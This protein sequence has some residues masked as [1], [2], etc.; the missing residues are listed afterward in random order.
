M[1]EGLWGNLTVQSGVSLRHGSVKGSLGADVLVSIQTKAASPWG[2]FQMLL[3]LP[4]CSVRLVLQKQ[5]SGA[6]AAAYVWC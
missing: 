2:T 1:L 4:R 3:Y 6:A 5:D